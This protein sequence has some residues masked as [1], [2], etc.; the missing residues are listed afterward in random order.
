MHARMHSH[1]WWIDASVRNDC[2]GGTVRCM[3]APGR[4]S[5]RL[6]GAAAGKESSAP[7]DHSATSSVGNGVRV[8]E[9]YITREIRTRDGSNPLQVVS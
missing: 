8:P 4:G 7:D 9:M 3:R 6:T 1:V 5:L 2:M